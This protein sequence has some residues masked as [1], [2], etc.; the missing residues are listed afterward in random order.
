MPVVAA[1]AALLTALV[2]GCGDEADLYSSN[3]GSNAESGTTSV[4]N[5]FIV[6]A[7]KPGSCAIQVG[8]SADLRFTVSNIRPAESE[9][10]LQ[11]TTAAA[12]TV[13]ISPDAEVAIPA[14]STVAAG[15]PIENLDGPTDTSFTVTLEGLKDGVTPGKSVDVTFLFEKFGELLLRVPVDSC[16]TQK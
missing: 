15:Q 1:A 8:D 6:P 9:R 14:E 7:F 11:I 10:L 13:R 3:R 4:E 5:V 16:P 2:A 12:D